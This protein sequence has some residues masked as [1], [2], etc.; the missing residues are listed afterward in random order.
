MSRA[1]GSRSQQEDAVAGA[2]VLA[3]LHRNTLSNG[4][5]LEPADAKSFVQPEQQVHPPSETQQ[6]D[7]SDVFLGETT[8]LRYVHD[9]SAADTPTGPPSAHSHRLRYSVPSAARAEALIPDWEAERR[10]Q[11]IE[12][13]KR[14]GAFSLPSP[15][16]IEGL[17]KAYFQWFHPCFAI[18][19]EMEVWKQYRQGRLPI[20]LLQ[21]MLFIG[22]LHCDGETLQVLGEGSRHRAKYIFY[23]HAK[24]LYDAEYETRKFTVIQALFLMSFWRAGA[25]LEKDTRHWLSA[26]ISLAQTKALHR[27]AGPASN[28][29]AKLRRRVW[30]S[31]YTRDRQCSA[32][33]GL[34]NR[35]RDE[36]C[37]SESLEMSDF[38][39]AFDP[40]I[41]KKAA[42]EYATYAVGM[43]ELS[44]FLGTCVDEG[45]FLL[46]FLP[47]P[48]CFEAT[49][50][51]YRVSQPSTQS[52]SWIYSADS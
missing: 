34:P 22:V 24:D 13:L 20:I 42:E 31:L 30:W 32:A 28:Q 39:S 4:S 41:S 12:F 21:A 48:D 16:A 38:D 52:A 15:V 43:A 45:S 26:A 6:E 44:K 14:D 5:D 18:V 1:S 50:I 2:H 49:E 17:L 9:Q 37:D 36:D 47:S 29:I 46:I 10:R 8:S 3:S 40:N 23:N 11:R 27:S 7:D 51:A 25:L 35:V 33:L 19:D